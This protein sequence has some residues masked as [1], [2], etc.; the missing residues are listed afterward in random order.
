MT[1]SLPSESPPIC[2][3]SSDDGQ[4]APG[5]L[6]RVDVDG[7]ME[8]GQYRICREKPLVRYPQTPPAHYQC[9]CDPCSAGKAI[10]RRDSMTSSTRAAHRRD[11]STITSRRESHRSL[12]L[13]SKKPGAGSARL[14]GQLARET[15]SA[16][17]AMPDCLPAGC[18]SQAFGTAVRL[19]QCCLSRRQRAAQSPRRDERR[20]RR[21]WTS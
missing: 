4:A 8:T 11:R 1:Q 17:E 19:R 13:P 21:G 6:H 3:K 2:L 12:S 5:H 10:A 15:G 7:L 14:W 9:G 18:A 16:G 20:T